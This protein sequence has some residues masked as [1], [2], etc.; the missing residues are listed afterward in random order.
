MKPGEVLVLA[1]WRAIAYQ[2]RD[3]LIEMGHVAHSYFQEEALDTVESQQALT[4][5]TLI[6]DPN[7]RVALR[8]YLA[9]SS[10]SE[11]RAAYRRICTYGQEKGLAAKAVL[12]EIAAGKLRLPYMKHAG[13][14]F[15]SLKSILATLEPFVGEIEKLVNTLCPSG[16]SRTRALREAMDR[17]LLEPDSRK[18]VKTFATALRTQIGVPEVPLDAPFVRL[19]SLHK[20]KGLTVKL[21]VIAGLVEGLVPRQPNESLFGAELAE[22]EQEQRRI[23]FVGIT[24]PTHE[25]VLSGFQEID[26]RSAHRSGAVTGNWVGRGVKRTVSSSLLR[27]LGPELPR[28][29]RAEE[30][31]Y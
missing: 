8:T 15:N 25:L 17:T 24:R 21:V 10:P 11:N 6:A 28:V 12:D 7:D 3:R 27:E 16:D 19:M 13:A 9:L 5:L 2:I 14:T 22:H 4:L 26:A 29:V 1:N 31:K 18:D 30:W 23:L 20:S